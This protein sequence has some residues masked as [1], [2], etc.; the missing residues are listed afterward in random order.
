MTHMTDPANGFLAAYENATNSHR[1]ELVLELVHPE[2]TYWFTDGSHSGHQQIGSAL[3]KTWDTITNETY[4]ILDVNWIASDG[5]IAS[6]T[7]RFEWSG[8]ID[9]VQRSGSGRGTSVLQRQDERWL[10]LHEH[11]SE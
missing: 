8:I 3:A 5:D 2:A 9:D 10:V 6:C 11:L 4:R 1:P 7:Y